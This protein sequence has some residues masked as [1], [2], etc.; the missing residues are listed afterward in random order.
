MKGDFLEAEPYC[1]YIETERRKGGVMS[2]IFLVDGNSYVYR[3]FF[4]TPYL[5]N[6]KGMP[7]NAIYA[8]INM[9]KEAHQRAKARL[10]MVVVWDSKA[11]FLPY[12]DIAGI[13]GDEAAHARAT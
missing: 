5:S 4:A 11:P 9:I 2:R 7:T 3:A 1:T 6:S 10:G 8:F 13:Q 12:T